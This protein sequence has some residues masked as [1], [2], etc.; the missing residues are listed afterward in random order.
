MSTP[1][2]RGAQVSLLRTSRWIFLQI[3]GLRQRR[4]MHKWTKQISTHSPDLALKVGNGEIA[5]IQRLLSEWDESGYTVFSKKSRRTCVKLS[6][7][8][9]GTV[10][11]RGVGRVDFDCH[12]MEPR[13][14]QRQADPGRRQ[15]Y[16][17]GHRRSGLGSSI[18][19]WVE[20]QSSIVRPVGVVG[21]WM[22][23]VLER[24]SGH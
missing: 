21:A 6:C 24:G 11:Q 2:S 9:Q 15:C 20:C 18:I 10:D 7:P 22:P 3:L 8:G 12:R 16:G 19:G 1:A 13:V 23:K 14:G 4:D 17:N 5:L